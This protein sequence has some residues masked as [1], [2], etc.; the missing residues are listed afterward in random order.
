M[1]RT[2]QGTI[3]LETISL[4]VFNYPMI[5]LKFITLI[6]NL[7]KITKIDQS[8]FFTSMIVSITIQRLLMVSLKLMRSIATLMRIWITSI[9]KTN[10]LTIALSTN[11]KTFRPL[12]H[13]GT[14]VERKLQILVTFGLIQAIKKKPLENLLLMRRNQMKSF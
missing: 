4:E 6:V 11:S 10:T 9:T 12:I 7:S 13:L 5:I 2:I 8:F 1:R 3:T 14:K